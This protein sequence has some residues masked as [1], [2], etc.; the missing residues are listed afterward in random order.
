MTRHSKSLGWVAGHILINMKSQATRKNRLALSRALSISFGNIRGLNCNVNS[1]HQFLS[2]FSPSVLFLTET[3]ISGTG[4]LTHLQF[5]NYLLFHSFRLK[6]GVCAYVHSSISVTH[7]TSLDESNPDFQLFW[8]KLCHPRC[9]RYICCMY[10]S[11]N[12]SDTSTL[13]SLLN[14][15]CENFLQDDPTAELCI[16]GDFNV[17]NSEWLS[18]SSYTDPAGREA[19][20]FAITN[21]FTQLVNFPTR[22]PDRIGDTPQTLDLFLTTHPTPYTISSFAPLG[23]SDHCIITCSAPLLSTQPPQHSRRV[24]WRYSS[25]DWEGLRQFFGAYPWESCIS[26]NPSMFAEKLTDIIRDGM[27]Q[28]V[29]HFSKPGKRTSPEW[30][31]HACN[32]AVRKKNTL[33]KKWRT[34]PSTTSRADYVAARNSCTTIIDRAKEMFV[35]RKANQLS[36]APAGSRS[37]WSLAKAVSRNFCSSSFPPILDADGSLKTLPAEKAEIFAHHFASISSDPPSIPVHSYPQ[38]VST[39]NLPLITTRSVRRALSDLDTSKPPG[40]DGIPPILFR[41]CAPELAPVISK[42]FRLSLSSGTFPSTWKSSHILPIPKFGSLS[43]PNNYRPIS[44]TPI[45]SKVLETLLSKQLLCDLENNTLLSDHQ[46]GF[47]RHRSTGD[48]LAYVSH[49]WASSMDKFG[50]T[51]LVSLDISKAFDRVWHA[52]LL[53]KLPMYGLH[54]TLVKWIGSFLE[55]RSI[56]VRLDGVVSRTRN[57]CTGVPQGSVLSPTLFLLFINDL[58]SSVSCNIHAFADDATLHHSIQ[59]R[60]QPQSSLR[61]SND[62]AQSISA[63]NSDLASIARWGSATGTTF[64]PLKSAHVSITLRHSSHGLPLSLG[65]DSIPHVPSFT[66]LGLSF[67]NNLSWSPHIKLI[68]SRASRKVG[69]LFRARKFFTSSQLLLIYK[70]QIRPT[71]E[72]CCHVWGGAPSSYLSLL[73]SIQRKC[74]RLIGAPTLTNN[75]QSLSHRRDVASL[76]LFYRYY[77]GR[78]SSELASSVPLPQ[79]FT[80]STR[81]YASSNPYQVSISRCRTELFASSFFPR[82]SRLWNSLPL[83][84]FPTSY[85]LI[86][87]KSRVNNYLLNPP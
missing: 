21:S 37:F 71:L 78:C 18:H 44:I 51:E 2:S 13:F 74:V 85:N 55:G 75:L 69:F 73:D 36:N 1:V 5:P 77:H 62:R 54:P 31:N 35:R 70:S 38:P 84:I 39:F 33:F 50:E 23:S 68:A 42:L 30:F 79:S 86:L 60:S 43:N 61:V 56:Q 45:L 25:A 9:S 65:P 26:D 87:F 52:D 7:L 24:F 3:Q 6:G 15:H 49:V 14:S 47:R 46:Y 8:L 34:L 83:H 17:H 48:M 29:P 81:R 53:A 82:T 57:I 58:L 10:R 11:P 27:A 28:F 4:D 20:F 80:R 16:L 64:N 22:I 67:S 19:E 66:L 12:S 72:Y 59:F 40:P 76:S 32:R 41:N 63:L